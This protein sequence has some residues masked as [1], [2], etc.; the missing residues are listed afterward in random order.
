MVPA[1]GTC[2]GTTADRPRFATCSPSTA[3]SS[4]RSWRS[5]WARAPASTSCRWTVLALEVHER[6]DV[7]ARG[8]VRRV[9]GGPLELRTFEDS[10]ASWDAA[11]AT[12]SG[13][14]PA[15][16]LTDLYYLDHYGTSAHFPGHAVVLAGF[17]DE[18][19]YL[20]DT[21][22]EELQI[23]TIASLADA[24]HAQHPVFPLAGHMFVADNGIDSFD[25]RSAAP[26]A[27]ARCAERMLEPPLGEY[28]GLPG[29]RKF[30]AEVS[31]WPELL[32][33]WQWSAR[34][35]YQTIERRGT[36]G[37]N[38]RLMYSRFLDE[39]G[40]EEAPSRR[41]RPSAGPLWPGI[42]SPRATR[43]SSAALWARIGTGA[44][45]ELNAEERLWGPL[46]R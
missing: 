6:P 28:E 21:A 44:G 22:F 4:A 5:A 37:G 15:L 9:D 46:S 17:D 27:V 14:A 11:S 42:C 18:V 38:F 16:L 34:F 35:T 31:S 25:P 10:G 13:G 1:T 36:G 29:L 8:A 7:A 3:S 23:T 33:D 32:S 39:A 40:Y 19:A 24:R 2:Q 20:S 45:A 43:T 12:V 30:A 41:P 26:T